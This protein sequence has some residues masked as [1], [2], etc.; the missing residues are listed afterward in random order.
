MARWQRIALW[1]LF[2]VAACLAV[3]YFVRRLNG[4]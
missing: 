1:A 4:P 2:I 3:A